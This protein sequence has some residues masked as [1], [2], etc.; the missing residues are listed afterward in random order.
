MQGTKIGSGTIHQFKI[1]LC[2]DKT[3]GLISFSH[4]VSKRV[5]DHAV[6]RILA[7][8]IFSRAIA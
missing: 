2:G 8:C 3:L 1:D 7:A 5:N 4:Y 6:A